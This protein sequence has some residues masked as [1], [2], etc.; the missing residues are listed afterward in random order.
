M[1]DRSAHR[2]TRA[3]QLPLRLR[4]IIR[5][6]G[7]APGD[8]L[9]SIVQLARRLEVG[10]PAMREALRRLET[11]G[12]VEIRHGTGVFVGP[13]AG[14]AI[15]PGP[16][17]ARAI[18]P[19]LLADAVETRMVLER[20]A[21]ALAA[22]NARDVHLARMR[23]LLR[24]AETHGE[25]DDVLAET[26]RA[27]H[28]CIAAASGNTVL[29]QLL[30]VL[31]NLIPDDRR[32]PRPCRREGRETREHAGILDALAGRDPELAMERM[33][34]HLEGWKDQLLAADHRDAGDL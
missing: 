30:D 9:P 18:S 2:P 6:G 10:A 31:A 5:T 3:D 17:M 22:R 13:H 23:E 7:Y 25:G 4:E 34:A 26:N 16:L 27:F 29:A 19:T 33:Q 28:R 1:A 32:A 14:A 20:Q 21:V 24:H 11:L 15:V 8:R 12:V